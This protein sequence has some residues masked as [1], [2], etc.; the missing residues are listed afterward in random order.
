MLTRRR[1]IK[2]AAS[3]AA[4]ST[5]YSLFEARDVEVTPLELGL[6]LGVRA[7]HITDTHFSTSIFSSEKVAAAISEL[8]PEMIFHT[9]DLLTYRRGLGE[10]VEFL[11]A[12]RDIA[13]VY[14]VL[15]NHDH[16]SGIGAEGLKR[17]LGSKGIVVLANE[18]VRSGDIVIAGVDDPYTGRDNLEK[19]L[20]SA[21]DVAVK[22]LLAHSPQIIGGASSRVDVVL[23]GHTHGGQVRFPG[24]GALWVPLPRK[25]RRFEYGLFRVGR[26]RMFVSRGIGTGYIPLRLN[27]PP[28]IVVV[29]L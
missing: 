11:E 23:T 29:N 17:V 5:G 19:A 12:L 9:G 3:A 18:A 16:W 1:F 21:G 14:L 4:L 28:E 25:Y 24:I 20:G 10:A 7:V 15:G 22:L 6:G 13:P 2:V 26:A 27:C 8:N